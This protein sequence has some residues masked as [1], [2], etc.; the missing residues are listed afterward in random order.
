MAY[1][2]G[3]GKPLRNPAWVT[4]QETPTQRDRRL[5]ETNEALKKNEERQQEAANRRLFANLERQDLQDMR[6]SPPSPPRSTAT[7]LDPEEEV[8][9]FVGAQDRFE[10][11]LDSRFQGYEETF[12]LTPLFGSQAYESAERLALEDWRN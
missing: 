7:P 6:L 9:R 11:F 4:G 10:G 2:Y 3:T 12:G 8:V 5:R 1:L